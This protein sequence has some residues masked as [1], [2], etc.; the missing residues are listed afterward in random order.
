M[1]NYIGRL[2]IEHRML[3]CSTIEEYIDR[4]W[5]ERDNFQNCR[6][7]RPLE[8]WIEASVSRIEVSLDQ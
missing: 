2:L 8:K 6:N 3:S 7:A 5:R 1:Y 4:I